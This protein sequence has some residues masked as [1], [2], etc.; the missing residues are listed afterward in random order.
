MT[1]NA[2]FVDAN[3]NIVPL[4]R[5]ITGS[6]YE[7]DVT[8][9]AAENSSPIVQKA[10][11]LYAETSMFIKCGKTDSVTAAD[12]DYDVFLPAGSYREYEMGTLQYISAVKRTGAA[13]GKLYING[14]T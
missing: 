12:D 2:A 9:T 11:G 6:D 14:L 4:M 10:V 3:Q 1:D 7:I 5:P 8:G 13:D